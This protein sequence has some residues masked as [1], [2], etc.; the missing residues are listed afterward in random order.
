MLPN[1]VKARLD[2]LRAAKERAKRAASAGDWPAAERAY[3]DALAAARHIDQM[4]T[5]GA[6]QNL[7][8]VCRSQGKH[9]A[10]AAHLEEDVALMQGVY[11]A[12]PPRGRRPRTTR[13][14]SS[15]S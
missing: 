9:D 4:Q 6:L 11:G 5:G 2:E 1:D 3:T 15:I 10:S 13:R 8:E 7:A 12:P 14:C